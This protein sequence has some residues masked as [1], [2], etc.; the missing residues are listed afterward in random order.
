MSG[1]CLLWNS[2]KSHRGRHIPHSISWELALIRYSPRAGVGSTAVRRNNQWEPLARTDLLT[3]RHLLPKDWR[4]TFFTPSY[5]HNCQINCTA[6]LECF[7]HRAS[8]RI[9]RGLRNAQRHAI[10]KLDAQKKHIH[11]C[12]IARSQPWWRWTPISKFH[13][14][15]LSL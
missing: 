6:S 3:R 14:L 10:D 7:P 13:L 15:K 12:A 4:F 9:I 2:E 11:H 5:L 1:H 8:R